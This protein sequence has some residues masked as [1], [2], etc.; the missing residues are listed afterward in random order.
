[1]KIN[2][3]G[4]SINGQKIHLIRF[5]DDITLMAGS[6]ENLNPTLNCLDATLTKS[7]QGKQKYL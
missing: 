7:M 6:E 3:S 4:I 2:T 5:T 1:M